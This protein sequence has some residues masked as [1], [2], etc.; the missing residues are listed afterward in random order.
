[1]SVFPTES[2]HPVKLDGH[3]YCGSA[4]TSF[5]N[6]SRNHVIK[7]SRD[8][9]GCVPHRKLLFC[10]FWWPQTLLKFRYKVLHL[11]HDHLMK[12]SRNW[13]DTVTHTRSPPLYGRCNISNPNANFNFNVYK[14][15]TFSLNYVHLSPAPFVNSYKIKTRFQFSSLYFVDHIF[16]DYLVE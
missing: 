5:L 1:M 4:D 9:E 16:N 12:R 7:R 13:V 3:R 6:L 8:V 11:S 14:L 15:P 2:Y 10:K